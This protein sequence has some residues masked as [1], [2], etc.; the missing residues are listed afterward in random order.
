MLRG[1]GYVAADET[2]LSR[3]DASRR[4]I[5]SGKAFLRPGDTVVIEKPDLFGHAVHFA[6]ARVRVLGVPV[7]TNPARHDAGVD[8]PGDRGGS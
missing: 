1:E 3:T 8:V 2:C 4:W 5:Y 6:G 7:R